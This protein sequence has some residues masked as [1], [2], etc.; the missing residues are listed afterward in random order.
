MNFKLQIDCVENILYRP[1]HLVKNKPHQFIQM[2]MMVFQVGSSDIK[3][4]FESKAV[5][6]EN[7]A[8]Y[9]SFH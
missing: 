5:N 4:G 3:L 1:L 2:Q 8:R 6:G 9:L 7:S